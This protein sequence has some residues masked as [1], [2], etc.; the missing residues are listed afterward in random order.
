M[1]HECESEQI[2]QEMDSQKRKR[3][4]SPS[5]L[6]REICPYKMDASLPNTNSEILREATN[7]LEAAFQVLLSHTHQQYRAVLQASVNG[8]KFSMPQHDDCDACVTK[9]ISICINTLGLVYEH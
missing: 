6:P 3:R 5:L 7:N 4:V 9:L 2:T 8:I 1:I